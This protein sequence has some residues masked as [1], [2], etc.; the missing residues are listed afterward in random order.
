MSSALSKE[1]GMMET[2]LKRW[3]DAA[4]EAVSLRAKAHSLREKLSVKVI[5]TNC[6]FIFF[7]TFFV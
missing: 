4:H 2:Q 5:H 6:H 3:K 7:L 1:M